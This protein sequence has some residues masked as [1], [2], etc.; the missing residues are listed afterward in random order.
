MKTPPK[1]ALFW[2]SIILGI[3]LVT[4]SLVIFCLEVGVGQSQPRR[5][6]ALILERQ[7][8]EGHNLFLLALFGL[9]PF[10]ALATVCVVG[11]RWWAESR[12]ACVVGG[13]LL[14]I[15]ALMVWS[16]VQIWYP[17]YGGGHASSTSV[18]AFL[19]IPFYCLGTLLLGAVL[20]WG[21]SFL[22]GFR[23]FPG[24]SA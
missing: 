9:I 20:G 11:A 4:P 6:V 18:I 23:R 12:L 21:V 2:A 24:E 15:L 7:F 14:G 22:P 10:L 13:G 8:A 1:R 3:G 19:F 17:L 16:H 5:A